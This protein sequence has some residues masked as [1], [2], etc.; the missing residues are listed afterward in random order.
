MSNTEEIILPDDPRAAELKTI[1]VWV[2]RRGNWYREES[3]EIARWDGSTHRKCE[4]GDVTEKM[5]T[6][7]SACRRKKEDARHAQRQTAPWDGQSM[8]YSDRLDEYFTDEDSL[9]DQ[10]RENDMSPADAVL[11]HCIPVRAHALDPHDIYNDDLPED[12][13][14]PAGIAEAF[15]AL[16]Q[17]LEKCG[18]LGWIAGKVAVDVSDIRM[19]EEAA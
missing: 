15:A 5:W 13:E 12:G 18:P 9:K 4:C 10:L 8:I 14:L 11:L 3:E 19:E 17:A 7:C 6:I 1:N 2:S 16:N